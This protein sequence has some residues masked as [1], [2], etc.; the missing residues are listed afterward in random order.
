MAS[1]LIDVI[2]SGE[3]LGL[4]IR[5]V[6][7][8][9]NGPFWFLS[10]PS[11]PSCYPYHHAISSL[12]HPELIAIAPAPSPEPLAL[13]CPPPC[14]TTHL[15]PPPFCH[16]LLCCSLSAFHLLLS[17]LG[18][19]FPA[20][21]FVQACTGSHLEP[22][23]RLLTGHPI[24]HAPASISPSIYQNSRQVPL[25]ECEM[26]DP[27]ILWIIPN[28]LSWKCH[29]AEAKSSCMLFLT[30]KG[31]QTS[32][33]QLHGAVALLRPVSDIGAPSPHG[34]PRDSSTNSLWG[35]AMPVS[36]AMRP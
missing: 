19:H 21:I 30:V 36:A 26:M 27:F 22:D 7:K 3:Y 35:T 13:I 18:T 34:L 20:I 9:T 24:G 2:D 29:W 14:C 15:P 10:H 25:G 33:A 17:Q 31:T 4:K 8:S 23:R 5:R 11:L 16:I 32:Q 6:C 28:T 1:W 12:Q